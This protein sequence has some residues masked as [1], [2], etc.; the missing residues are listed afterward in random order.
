MI[1][2]CNNTFIGPWQYNFSGSAIVWLGLFCVPISA[3]APHIGILISI[4]MYLTQDLKI[5]SAVPEHR[6][7]R[8]SFLASC[9]TGW[10]AIAFPA[11]VRAGI[12][13]LADSLPSLREGHRGIFNIHQQMQADGTSSLTSF[14]GTAHAMMNHPACETLGWQSHIAVSGFEPAY[15]LDS[16]QASARTE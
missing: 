2:F 3:T 11:V 1:N 7:C 5:P 6:C 14:W 15:R 8:S 4:L 12:C 10:F 16:L 13:N 9:Y